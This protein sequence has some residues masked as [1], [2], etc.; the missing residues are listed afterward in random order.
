MRQPCDRVDTPAA[1][2][3]WEGERINLF[4][5]LAIGERVG[6]AGTD[7]FRSPM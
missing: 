6:N 7:L 3:H 5:A 2:T 1:C 4:R